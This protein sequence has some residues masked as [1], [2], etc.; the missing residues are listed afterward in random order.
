MALKWN[1]WPPPPQFQFAVHLITTLNQ[2]HPTGLPISFVLAGEGY[3]TKRRREA[4]RSIYPDVSTINIL[5][6]IDEDY[7][8]LVGGGWAIKGEDQWMTSVA[9]MNS[10]NCARAYVH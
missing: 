1:S 9:R 2:V 6:L 4:L 3:L 8:A 10:T 7:V 5:D